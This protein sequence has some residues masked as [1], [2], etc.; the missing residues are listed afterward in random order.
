MRVSYC[1]SSRRPTGLIAGPPSLRTRLSTRIVSPAPTTST[2]SRLGYADRCCAWAVPPEAERAS[3]ASAIETKRDNMAAPGVNA[4]LRF[5][6]GI[7]RR[8]EPASRG[9]LHGGTS[10][11]EQIPQER[12]VAVRGVLAVA[13]DR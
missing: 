10:L 11:D 2:L 9:S 3:P 5:S 13:A 1:M 8:S 4:C 12:A 6:A 7:V